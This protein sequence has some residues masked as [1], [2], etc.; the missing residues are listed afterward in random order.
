MIK[1]LHA[2]KTMNLVPKTKI[3]NQKKCIFL[4]NQKKKK[5]NW[6]KHKINK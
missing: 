3:L 6:N 4:L 2:Y 1:T 5:S